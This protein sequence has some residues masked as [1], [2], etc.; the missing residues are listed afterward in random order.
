MKRRLTGLATAITAAALL[1]G[2]GGSES[3]PEDAVESF[4]NAARDDDAEGACELLSAASIEA[5]EASGDDCPTSFESEGVGDIPDDIE[6]GE[7]T[8]DG[9]T[10]TVQVSGDGEEVE[11]PTVNEDDEWKVDFAALVPEISA[12]EP[13]VSVPEGI[14]P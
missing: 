1:A 3:T 4:F 13:D 9:D 14:E 11:I 12:E 10:A 7:V 5:I 2:C 6:I 8:E